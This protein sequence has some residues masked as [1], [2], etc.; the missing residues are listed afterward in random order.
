MPLEV[1]HVDLSCF[2][3]EHV[4][5]GTEAQAAAATVAAAAAVPLMNFSKAAVLSCGGTKAAKASSSLA[6][7]KGSKDAT[8]LDAEMKI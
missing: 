2:T 1:V 8:Q 6:S 5:L 3:L 4:D 7:R